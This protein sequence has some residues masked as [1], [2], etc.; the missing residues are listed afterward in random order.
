MKRFVGL[1]LFFSGVIFIIFLVNLFL[2]SFNPTYHSALVEAVTGREE[3]EI[4]VVDVNRD[5]ELKLSSDDENVINRDMI[6]EDMEDNEVP[7]SAVYINDNA[8]DSEND[9]KTPVI[10]DKEYHEDCGTGE[11]YWII[12]YDDGSIEI[13]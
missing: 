13:E 4:P 6:Y 2:Y 12:K 9:E 3:E 11:G 8:D 5:V 1:S 10:V 7:L